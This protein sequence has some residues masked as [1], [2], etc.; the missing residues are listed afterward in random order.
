MG[1]SCT[2]G[3][4]V[5]KLMNHVLYEKDRGFFTWSTCLRA[6]C[7]TTLDVSDCGSLRP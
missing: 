1:A 2:S 4:S 5:S 3:K 7:T 6:Q